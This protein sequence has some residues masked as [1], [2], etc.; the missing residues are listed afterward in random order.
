MPTAVA[1]ADGGVKQGMIPVTPVTDDEDLYRCVWFSGGDGGLYVTNPDGSVKFGSMAF[2]DRSQRPS[3]DRAAL[4]NHDP[5]W[6][7]KRPSAGVA[8]VVAGKVRGIHLEQRDSQNRV[9]GN[10]AV[11]VEHRPIQGD[12]IEPDNPAH[13]EIYTSP[14]CSRSAFRRLCESLS[15]LANETGWLIPPSPDT[16]TGD[17]Q[18]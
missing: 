11:D 1:L 8:K 14:V 7:Q 15:Y 4:C 10:V 6:T 16:D 18:P 13:A 12:I 9:L 17:Q 3:V 2:G 5:S